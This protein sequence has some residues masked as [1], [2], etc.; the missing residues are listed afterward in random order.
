MSCNEAL[1]EITGYNWTEAQVLK[2]ELFHTGFVLLVCHDLTQYSNV[3][4]F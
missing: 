4:Q 1:H 3:T 2:A